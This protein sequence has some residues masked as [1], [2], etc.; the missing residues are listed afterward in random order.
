MKRSSEEIANIVMEELKEFCPLLVYF[1]G[2]Y[3][4]NSMNQESDL[5][6]AFFS[7][8]ELDPME[9]FLVSQKIAAKLNC[10]VDLV[11]LKKSST[12]FQKEVVEHGLVVFQESELIRQEFELLVLKKYMRLNEERADILDAYVCKC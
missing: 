12:V 1:F 10:E 11:Q 2:S 3:V 7:K 4:S 9:V 8:D 6:I 5:D